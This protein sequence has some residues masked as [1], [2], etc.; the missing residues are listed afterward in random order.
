MVAIVVP[1]TADQ[2]PT[3]TPGRANSATLEHLALHSFDRRQRNETFFNG[4]LT[5]AQVD[6]ARSVPVRLR[7][8]VN[9]LHVGWGLLTLRCVY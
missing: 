8:A 4:G 6:A 7:Y 9:Q 5:A 3:L 1:A 2:V